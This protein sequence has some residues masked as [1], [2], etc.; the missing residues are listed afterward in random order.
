MSRRVQRTSARTLPHL[1]HAWLAQTPYA[2]NARAC[3]SAVS[4]M[5]TGSPQTHQSHRPISNQARIFHLVAR[6]PWVPV[7]EARNK[8][9]TH[10][11]TRLLPGT[12]PFLP[13]AGLHLRIAPACGRL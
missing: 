6:A 4:L 3:C 1:S 11:A 9:D 12:R 2:A 5:S 7:A 13:R 8:I 10:C